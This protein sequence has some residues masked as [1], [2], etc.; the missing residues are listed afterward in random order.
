MTVREG[1]VLTELKVYYKGL[2]FIA[3]AI[4][5]PLE[6]KEEDNKI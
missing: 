4:P 2:V 1:I 6:I 5:V 3:I